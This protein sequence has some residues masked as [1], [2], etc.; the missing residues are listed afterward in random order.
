MIDILSNMFIL[1]FLFILRI[2]GDRFYT[3]NHIQ[4]LSE[5]ILYVLEKGPCY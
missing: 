4:D 5:L 1:N 2:I 3:S